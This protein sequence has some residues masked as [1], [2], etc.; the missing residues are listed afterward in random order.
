MMPDVGKN[1]DAAR[2]D[3]CATNRGKKT[4]FW[5]KVDLVFAMTCLRLGILLSIAVAGVPSASAQVADIPDSDLL[6]KV[7]VVDSANRP[8]ANADVG[9]APGVGAGQ[10]DSAGVFLLPRRPLDAGEYTVTVSRVGYRM[11]TQKIQIPADAAALPVQVRIQLQTFIP[12][13]PADVATQQPNYRVYE[14]FYA[15]D[16]KAT[17][18]TDPEKYYIGEPNETGQLELGVCQVSLPAIHKRGV[19]EGPSLFRLEFQYDPEKHVMM[20][21]PQPLKTDQYFQKLS[22]RV[23][24]SARKEAFV[25]VH[26]Y[27]VMFAA[28]ARRAIQLAADLNF[29]GAPILYS[30]PSMGAYRG[31]FSDEK[32]VAWSAPHLEAFLQQVAERSGATRVHLIAHSM[33]NRALGEALRRISQSSTGVAPKFQQIVLAAPDIRVNQIQQIERAMLPLAHRVTLYASRNDDALILARI[34]DGVARAGEQIHQVVVPGID[35]VDASAVRTDFI[36]HGYIADSST[37]IADLKQLLTTDATPQN[38]RLQPAKLADLL[39]WVIPA[40]PEAA[41]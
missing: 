5:C 24:Q 35:A 27:N 26:G 33:G 4:R 3:A 20:R 10:T 21:V 25:F 6:L 19:L 12:K 29:D 39:Y 22:T 41:K 11:R 16:R 32:R 7:T 36:G 15:T 8:V 37:V 14:L 34:L 1:A 23:N 40:P 9:I 17:R 31:Y 30:W 38:R 18:A 13:P 2:L 28:A